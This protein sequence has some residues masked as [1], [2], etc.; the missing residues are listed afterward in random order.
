MNEEN[1]EETKKPYF[2]WPHGSSPTT[3]SVGIEPFTIKG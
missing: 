1:L 2:L 3:L